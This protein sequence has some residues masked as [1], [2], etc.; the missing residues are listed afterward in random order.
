MLVVDQLDELFGREVAA[1]ERARFA[2]L[3]ALF[4]ETGRVWVVATLRA[5]LYERFLADPVL[6]GLKTGGGAYD[7][8][9][10]GPAELVEIVQKPAEA[11]E[12]VFETDPQ[13]GARPGTLRGLVPDAVDE[14]LGKGRRNSPGLNGQLRPGKQ[15][16]IALGDAGP[17]GGLGCLKTAR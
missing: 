16:L 15:G 13:S 1:D 2:H 14:D 8:T 5:D 17:S 7:I 4:V 12:L 9:P 6:L 3:L 11:A 10:P